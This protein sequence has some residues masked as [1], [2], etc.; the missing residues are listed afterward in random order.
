[1]ESPASTPQGQAAKPGKLS[2]NVWILTLTSFLTDVSS[3]MIL[4]LIPLFLVGVLGVRTSVVG[5]IEGVAETTASLMK[6]FSGALSDRLGKRKSLAVLGYGLS[7]VAKPFLYLANSW[8]WVLGVRFSDRLGK[9]IRT[10]PRDALLAGSADERQRG[11]AFGVQRAGDTAGAFLGIAIAAFIIANGAASM[12]HKVTMFFTFWGLNILR[13]DNPP[14]VAKNFLERMFGWMMPK[15]AGK[16]KLSRLNMGGLGTEMMKR[17]M[18]SKNIDSLPALIASA[19]ENGVR[20]IACQMT[21]DMMGIKAEELI[22][23]VEIGG[24]ATYIGETDKANASL[25][26]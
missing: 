16:L 15:G 19:Q 2:R 10:A 25:F 11:L 12:G 22:D 6:I 5:L 18:K 4:N 21:M 9:G 23:G 24:V 20:L 1:M 26:I 8:G 17:V 7:T 14:S 13:K 3:E